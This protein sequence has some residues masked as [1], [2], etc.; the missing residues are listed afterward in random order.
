MQILLS[1]FTVGGGVGVGNEPTMNAPLTKICV[2]LYW[3]LLYY[4]WC[5]LPSSIQLCDH[6]TI[7]EINDCSSLCLPP[8]TTGWLMTM[9][10]PRVGEQNIDWGRRFMPRL[11]NMEA[12]LDMTNIA[13]NWV[14]SV[15]RVWTEEEEREEMSVCQFEPKF[16]PPRW[17]GKN[18]RCLSGRKRGKRTEETMRC[19]VVPFHLLAEELLVCEALRVGWAWR[20]QSICDGQ[21]KCHVPVGRQ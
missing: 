6:A 11:L 21:W 4:I 18:R 15:G 10:S 13:H 12:F 9:E 8:L 14:W 19:R 5:C 7:K 20:L 1:I 2:V 17:R 3:T 16:L